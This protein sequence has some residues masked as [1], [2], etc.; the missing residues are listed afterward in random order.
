M[1]ADSTVAGRDAFVTKFLPG[2]ASLAYSTF[3]G[4][5]YDDSGRGIAVDAAGNAHVTVWAGSDFP[6][7]ADGAASTEQG[8]A[9]Y[10]RLNAAGNSLAFSSYI[11]PALPHG[12]AVDS[13]D[14][15]YIGGQANPD[16]TIRNALQT[17]STLHTSGFLAK[18]GEWPAPSSP[19]D[20]VLY[21]AHAT[22]VAGAWR[23]VADPSAGGYQ[24][25]R[26]PDAAAP[27][28]ANALASPVHYFD[29]S[30]TPQT[31]RAYRLW[32][33]GRAER[34]HWSNDS[35]FVQFS[36]S[37][38][39]GGSPAYRIGTTAGTSVNLEDCASCGLSGWGWQDNGYGAGVRGPAIYFGSDA[40]QTIRIQTR[41][42]GM[43]IDQIVLSPATWF[44]AAP[45]PLKQDTTVLRDDDGSGAAGPAPNRDVVLHAAD[46][47]L[48]GNWRRQAD[49]TAAS[50]TRAW[51]PNANLPKRT[52]ALA[53]PADHVELTF[54]AEPGRPYRLWIRGKAENNYWGNDSAFVQFSGSVNAS[55]APVFRIGTTSATEYNLESCSGCGV[56][57]WGWED[58]GWGN[59]VL[60]PAL[61]FTAGPQTIRLQVREDGLSFDQIIL[62]PERFLT[63]APGAAKQDATIYPKQP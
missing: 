18:F 40:P 17:T 58:N 30:F 8:G 44:N 28:L 25:L 22:T 50:G 53:T 24:R 4:G 27:K 29:L 38:T 54:T 7:T 6:T 31:G 57:G 5:T 33:R 39:A 61:Y 45:G 46:A 1:A 60:G 10:A 59:G 52:A 19:D 32:I 11:G 12:L 35:V 51:N 55:G 9:F 21:A 36:H 56:S 23:R 34:D 13:A 41:E 14:N 47:R 49:A 42:D 62:S 48:T 63:A 37:V 20:I 16:M 26:H 15:V 43:M 2:G 3:I